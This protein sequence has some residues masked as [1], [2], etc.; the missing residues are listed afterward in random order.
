MIAWSINSSLSFKRVAEQAKL[1]VDTQLKT[2]LSISIVSYDSGFEEIRVLVA[3]L[4]DAIRQLQSTFT[5]T[6]IPLYLIDNSENPCL[7]LK[8]LVD[9]QPQLTALD[10]E[11]RLL[12]GHGNIG[13]GAAHNLA[14]A[15]AT[16]D[17]HLILNPDLVLDADC[18]V[19]GI[20]FMQQHPDVI[21]ASPLAKHE[22]G[23]KQHL[24]K[25]YPSVFTFL[26]RGFFPNFL[27]KL[28]DKRL[29]EFE[30][31]EL[32]DTAPNT[33]VPIVSGCF[34]LCQS[35]A[36]KQVQG[37]DANYF[38]Y[39]ED[40]DLSLRLGELGKVAYVPAMEI[41]HRGG[42]AARKGLH[43]IRLFI[44]SGIRFFNSH[45]WRFFRQS[46]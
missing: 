19:S 29:A 18:L 8:Q 7:S 35:S 23:E 46:S 41:Q 30:M 31:H 3:S 9:L 27:K 33:D 15:K 34:M 21:L 1:S 40:F 32:P 45:G 42:H 13:Y 39:F 4:L 28:F 12:S 20:T 11:L 25:R 5:A 10:I 6:A 44:R 26:V 43:H 14:I 2:P 24:C 36:L 38:L 22:N 17:Y 37:F 16:G